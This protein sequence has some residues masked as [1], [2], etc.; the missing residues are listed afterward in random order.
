M[1]RR[2]GIQ[3]G[4][5]ATD[6]AAAALDNQCK[7]IACKVFKTLSE[8][9]GD[10]IKLQ[11]KLTTAQIPGGIGACAPDGSL[12]FWDGKLVATF[13]AKKQQN[14]GNAI[15]RWF[16]N[17]FICRA[18][19]PDVSYVT[20]ACGEGAKIGGVIHKALAVAHPAGFDT[21]I[22]KGNSCWMKPE[23]FT[24][25]DIEM[26]MMNVLTSLCV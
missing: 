5:V 25:E 13:E 17:N 22:A 24:D 15:E 7:T 10:R 14:R 11:K 20:F 12:W 19:N 21:Y 9:Y 18:V 23:G 26:Y 8:R 1:P 4:Q 3:L 16:K 2:R 6:A